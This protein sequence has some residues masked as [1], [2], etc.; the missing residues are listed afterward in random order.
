M[1]R[2][3]SLNA[4]RQVDALASDQVAV[5]LVIIEHIDLAEPLRISSDN[6]DRLSTEPLTYGTLSTYG[7]VDGSAKPFYFVGMKVLPP[8]DEEDAEPTATLVIDVLDADMVNLLT[9]TTIAATGRIAIVMADTTQHINNQTL[10]VTEIWK[11]NS[12]EYALQKIYSSH[13]IKLTL[14]I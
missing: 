14:L 5:F 1:S 2:V 6:K 8:D 11:E 4:A 10:K 9:S 13:L 12:S 3:L 7:S